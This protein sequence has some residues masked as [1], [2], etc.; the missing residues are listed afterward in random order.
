MS[1]EEYDKQMWVLSAIS[2]IFESQTEDINNYD[3]VR[4]KIVGAKDSPYG[5]F[6]DDDIEEA[7]DALVKANIVSEHDGE[8]FLNTEQKQ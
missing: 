5:G 1:N 2:R 6:S 8:Y 7:L 3:D 4:E